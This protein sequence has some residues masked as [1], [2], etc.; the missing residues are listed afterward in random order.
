M[1]RWQGI[2]SSLLGAWRVQLSAHGAAGLVANTTAAPSMLTH[3]QVVAA[4]APTAVGAATAP[5]L[6]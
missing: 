2:Y 1:R 6:A 4:A 5:A 3:A